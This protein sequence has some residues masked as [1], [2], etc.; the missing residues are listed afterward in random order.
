MATSDGTRVWT[1]FRYEK[2]PDYCYIC[3]CLDHNDKDCDR[4]LELKHEGKEV[5]RGYGDYIRAKTY[6]TS[7][8][9]G[10]FSVPSSSNFS[11][12]ISLRDDECSSCYTL[13]IPSSIPN[14]EVV[15]DC[16]VGRKN[17]HVICFAYT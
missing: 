3:G 9:L 1:D 15:C 4:K 13:P 11:S 14:R 6:A 7:K 2:L 5:T 8:G 17:G 16:S 10:C 12:S